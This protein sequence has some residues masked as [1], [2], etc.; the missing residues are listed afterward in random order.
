MKVYRLLFA[1]SVGW[2]IALAAVSLPVACA[3]AF[4]YW[5]SNLQVQV[6]EYPPQPS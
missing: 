5:L 3:P 6:V 1:G 4:L 2:L